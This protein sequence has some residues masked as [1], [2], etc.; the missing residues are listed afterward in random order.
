[1]F[2]SDV[3]LE[4]GFWTNGETGPGMLKLCHSTWESLINALGLYT[5]LTQ[6]HATTPPTPPPHPSTPL[7]VSNPELAPLGASETFVVAGKKKKTPFFLKKKHIFFDAL[8]RGFKT[9]PAE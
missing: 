5:A 7:C 1:M 8:Q 2:P 6:H 9:A 4:I 3:K